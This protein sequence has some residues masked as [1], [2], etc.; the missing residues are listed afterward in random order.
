MNDHEPRPA[1]ADP[2]DTAILAFWW[3]ELG[4]DTRAAQE[5]IMDDC[6]PRASEPAYCR[7]CECV[8]PTHHDIVDGVYWQL[9][10]L[11]NHRIGPIA[12]R[13][14]LFGQCEVVKGVGLPGMRKRPVAET[15]N[16]RP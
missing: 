5:I 9:C 6:Q 8:R 1:D 15:E 13:P 14:P 16:L 12:T 10:V 7:I 4:P 2:L 11:C 3:R